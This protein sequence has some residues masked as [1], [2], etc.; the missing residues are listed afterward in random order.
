ME[1]LQRLKSEFRAQQR[2]KKF[3]LILMKPQ[4]TL[5]RVAVINR[6]KKL[7]EHSIK[8]IEKSAALSSK[9]C[10]LLDK[11]APPV[12]NDARR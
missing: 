5:S 4:P 3:K 11:S 9:H 12:S 8:R 7:R 1:E 10:H 2:R 6:P